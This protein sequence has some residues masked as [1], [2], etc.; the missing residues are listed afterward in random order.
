MV[1]SATDVV[2]YSGAG[3]CKNLGFV[4]LLFNVDL[5]CNAV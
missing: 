5:H 2:L 3:L 1:F 4:V